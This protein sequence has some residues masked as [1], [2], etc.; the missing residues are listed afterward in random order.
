MKTFFLNLYRK[1]PTLTEIFR[2]LL[3][4]GLA[5]LVDAS[6]M[7]LVQYLLEPTLYTDFFSLFTAKGTGYV[8]ILGTACGFTVGLIVN[9]FLSV[10]FVFEHKGKSKTP[11][12]FIV[13]TLLSLVDL[14]LH[15]L[16]MYIGNTLLNI[17]PWIVKIFMTAVVLVYNYISKRLILFKD[18]K[19][20]KTETETQEKRE[21][22]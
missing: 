14:G 2:F 15:I 5:T 10:F 7:A 8:Y 1:Y 9:Y 17:N 13:F 6:V 22:D 11:Y 12:G 21:N 19:K 16:G 18:G 20:T 4:G 3:V